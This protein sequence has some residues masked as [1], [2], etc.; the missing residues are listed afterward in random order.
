MT[1]EKVGV[2]H[3]GEMGISVAAS[4]KNSGR[5]VYW[6]SEDRSQKTRERAEKHGLRDAKTLQQLC[7]ACTTVISVC[8]PHAAEDVASQVVKCAYSGMYIDANAISPQRSIDIGQTLNKAGISY[9]DGGIVG[10]PAWQP[11][12]TWF[13]LAGHQAEAVADCFSAGPMETSIIGPAIGKA[14]ALKMCFAAY[15]KGTTALLCGIISTA[16]ALG[17]R[18]EL[19][20]QWGVFGPD[21]AEQSAQ[22]TRGVTAKA[23]RFIGE[24][25]EISKTFEEAGLPGGFHAAAAEIYSRLEHFKD[26]PELPSIEEVLASLTGDD[27]K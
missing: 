11:G 8:P 26:A 16:E 15:T 25:K 22:R 10:G 1:D 14:S 18:G 9:V 12:T 13:H 6:V 21:F 5:K 2:L 20:E 23:W 19:F 17:V 24:M 4:I 3:P 27:S 7:D